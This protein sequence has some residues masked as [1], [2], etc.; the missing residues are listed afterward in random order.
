MDGRLLASAM[1]SVGNATIYFNEAARECN[2]VKLKRLLDGG[3]DV[4]STDVVRHPYSRPPAD[5]VLRAPLRRAYRAPTARLR[6]AFS[7]ILPTAPFSRPPPPNHLT[8]SHPLS[9]D[10]LPYPPLPRPS[11]PPHPP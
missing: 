4:R 9:T 8:H 10:T 2:T 3:F 1:S 11:L 5:P 6:S 7:A